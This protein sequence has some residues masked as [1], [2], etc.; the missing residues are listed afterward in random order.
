[1]RHTVIGFKIRQQRRRLGITQGALAKRVGI[2]VSYMNL[3]EN[4]KRNIGGHLLR[5]IA[6]EL[7]LP[8][9][10]FDGASDRR[11]VHDLV[12]LSSEPMFEELALTPQAAADLAGQHPRWARA[13]VALNRS[14]HDRNQAITA[15]SDRLN[16]DPFLGES[17]HGMLT[18]VSAIRSASEILEGFTEL[19]ATDRARFLAIINHES[20]RLSDVA[21]ALAGFFDRERATTRSITPADEVDD[22]LQ[23]HD[24]FF[25]E[26]E[27]AADRIH[28]AA[29]LAGGS[30]ESRLIAYL[31]QQHGVD[32]HFAPTLDAASPD[33]RARSLYD[34][35]Q[36][37]LVLVAAAPLATR[38]FEL[39]RLV[40]L[41]ACQEPIAA[42]LDRS[43]LLHSAA[44]RH[45]AE[46]ALRAYVA[47]ALL[48]P[49]D[50]FFEAVQAA[51]YDIAHLCRRFGASFE[52][53]CHRLITLKKPGHEGVRFGFM[54]S[55]PAGY[56]TKR[57]PLPYMP[58]PRYGNACPLWAIYRA[59]Q[60]PGVFV[61][62][63][64]EFPDGRRYFFIAR[65]VEKQLPEYTATR[66]VTSLMLVCESIHA[67][68]LVYGDGL[69]LSTAAPAT[70]VGPTCR[71]CVRRDCA[72]RQENP[73]ISD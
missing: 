6:D 68:Q 58:L 37:R 40:A 72:S 7:E 24:N 14:L 60:T 59:F 11:L 41:L 28:D 1:M 49:Y 44:A 3:I 55:D 66:Q 64:A 12:D 43:T 5:R 61:R 25:P 69:D 52:Q 34:A 57:F 8:I 62:D 47:A 46:R 13:L 39:G 26:L 73:V 50:P 71:L 16:Q 33:P 20:G 65:T 67:D 70:P 2:S 4:N 19:E 53:V 27:R 10:R 15:L 35:A 32:V 45:L 29:G 38:R 42:A 17:I 51:R 31:R 9:E 30:A 63:L 18:N 22:F 54:R 48:L 23:E 56:V 21:Q 36:Q